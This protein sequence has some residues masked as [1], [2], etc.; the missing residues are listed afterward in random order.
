M[1]GMEAG[2]FEKIHAQLKPNQHS[3]GVEAFDMMGGWFQPPIPSSG[4]G[5]RGGPSRTRMDI[6]IDSFMLTKDQQQTVKTL[7][8][9]AQTSAAPV[10][11]G[12]AQ[13]RPAIV[14]A[15]Q[16]GKERAE[17]DSAVSAYATHAASMAVLEM[18][19]L[20]HLM[21]ALTP[22]QRA[23]QP[24]IRA[25]FYLLRG[26]FIGKRWDEAPNPDKGY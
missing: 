11:D 25:A 20:A 6:L 17:I 2:A 10:R 16:A 5:G 12:L 18:R 9:D 14:S 3:G 8:N 4:R 1:T 7:M 13:A 23:N 22:E 19:T 21:Q 15:I 26:A 24:G